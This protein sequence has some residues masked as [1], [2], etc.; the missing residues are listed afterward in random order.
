MT[1]ISGIKFLRVFNFVVFAILMLMGIHVF[2]FMPV[3]R[4]P[5][6]VEFTDVVGKVLIPLVFA[7]ALGS[8][9]K[10]AVE[11]WRVKNEKGG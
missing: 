6:Y 11:A 1:E 8:P 3:E 7:G 9:V 10:K 5:I 4:W 2:Y